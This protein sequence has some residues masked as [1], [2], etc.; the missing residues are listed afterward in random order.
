M[1]TEIW[2]HICKQLCPHCE[3]K[4]MPEFGFAKRK[5]DKNVT[6]H[7]ER[8]SEYQQG[9]S[10]LAALSLTSREMR[11]ISQPVLFH[12][13]YDDSRRNNTSK[14]LRTLISQPRLA[15][16]VR[17]LALAKPEWIADEFEPHTRRELEAWNEVGTRLGIPPPRWLSRVLAGEQPTALAP[18][19]VPAW[20]PR[21][22]PPEVVLMAFTGTGPDSHLLYDECTVAGDFNEDFRLWQHFIL[23]GLCSAR[24]THLA[25]SGT[26]RPLKE[27]ERLPV[28]SGLLGPSQHLERSFDF[29]RLR[30]FSCGKALFSKDFPSFFSRAKLLN[31][32]AVGSIHWPRVSSEELIASTRLDNVS[33]LSLSCYPYHFAHVL[34]LCPQVQDLEFHLEV[35][36]LDP[37]LIMSNAVPDPWPTHV[38]QQLRRLCFSAA[39]I[40]GWN[41]LSDEGKKLFPPLGEFQKLE[42]LEIDRVALQVGLGTARGLDM[43]RPEEF[44]RQLPD[45]LPPSIRIL[46]FSFGRGW[47]R[48]SWATLVVELEA[49]ATAKRTSSLP[50]LSVVQI[51]EPQWHAKDKTLAQVMEILG[52]VR[53]MEDAGIEL[54]FG[55]DP[56][57]LFSSAQG[58]GMRPPLPGNLNGPYGDILRSRHVENFFL[59]D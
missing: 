59:E 16:C 12:C 17:V 49:L 47:L 15:D 31:N 38:K 22:E 39:V 9:R 41:F 45:F 44:S 51:D 27:S 10:A 25:L 42:I 40:E 53:A 55:W 6:E 57:T 2:L 5:L 8:K 36:P 20:G 1:P 13:F 43:N 28:L 33:R 19:R 23:V 34:D 58:K 52:V 14:Y 37:A 24:I 50:M 35:P 11:D 18:W 30:V 7:G 48:L 29:P 26:Y 46:H 32:I 54:R 21:V 56:E 4:Q 3:C